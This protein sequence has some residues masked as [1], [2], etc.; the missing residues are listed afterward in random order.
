MVGALFG[1]EHAQAVELPP[2]LALPALPTPLSRRVRTVIAALAARRQRPPRL[3]IVVP[4]DVEGRARFAGLLAEDHVGAARSYVELLCSMHA[5][6]QQRMAAP[7]DG[8]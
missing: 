1:P 4:A 6:I 7:K 5:A 3:T 2:G 8:Y